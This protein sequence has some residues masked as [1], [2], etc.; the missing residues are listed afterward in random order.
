[1]K[2]YNI[3]I[4]T[5]LLILSTTGIY[6]QRPGQERIRTL[7][8]AFITERLGLTPKEAQQF[9]PVYNAH[10]K[11]LH[12]LRKKERLQFGGQLP[13]L[14]DLSENEASQ[15]LSEFKALQKEKHLL[16]QRLLNDLDNVLPAKKIILLLKA[17]EDFKK[18][19][20]QQ[21]RKR[22]GQ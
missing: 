8:I 5:L 21:V 12:E 22:R 15:L 3:K 11:A 10:D 20:L 2:H 4:I 18:R 9:W 17:E 16:E 6:A 13:F 7:K 1:M 19:L 14:N